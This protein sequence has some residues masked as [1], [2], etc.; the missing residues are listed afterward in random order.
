MKK[1]IVKEKSKDQRL[2]KFLTEEFISYSRG[3][4]IRNVKA[5]NVLVNDK[6]V[7][8]SYILRPGDVINS[9]VKT[10]KSK[11]ITSSSLNIKVIYE[12]ENV[13]VIDKPVGI[14]IHP[15]SKENKNTIVNW[16]MATYPEVRRVVDGSSTGRLRPGIVH[17]LDKDTS[18]VMVI[19][20]NMEFYKELQKLFKSRK[21]TKKYIALV[22]GKLNNKKGVID[23]P[24]ARAAT[25]KKQTVAGRKTMTKIREAVTEYK[26]I[27]EYKNTSLLE[28]IPK[29]GRMHQIRVH[30]FSIGH[31]VVGDKLYKLKKIKPI[32]ASRQMLH[33]Q[34]IKFKLF[35]KKYYFSS[36]L[37]RYFVHNQA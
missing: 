21:V 37:P 11:L 5:G 15:D 3:E 16:L 36:E 29:T 8:P 35:D 13:I 10:Q 2:D 26:V 31:P 7:K 25:Y 34:S 1:I 17:R 28:V 20:R 12:D 23:K 14:Q 18:G 33:A 32:K 30:L 22:Y 27:K 6:E 19:A 9:K 4:I 24:I